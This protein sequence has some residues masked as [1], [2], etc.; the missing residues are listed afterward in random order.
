M[1][2][3]LLHC[4]ANERA[5]LCRAMVALACYSTEA[6]MFEDFE[7]LLCVF[8]CARMKTTALRLWYFLTITRAG[9][10]HSLLPP[11]N[12]KRHATN[13]NSVFAANFSAQVAFSGDLRSPKCLSR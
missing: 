7:V 6:L 1:G 11:T 2:G 10:L 8:Q 9:S 4:Y 3:W 5:P 12:S 13:Y